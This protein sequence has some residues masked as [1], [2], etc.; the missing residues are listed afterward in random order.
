MVNGATNS[1]FL[2]LG[3]LDVWSFVGTVGDSNV[4]RVTASTFNPWIRLYDP[5]GDL[6]GEAVSPRFDTRSL[7]LIYEITKEPGIYTVV[8][9]STTGGYSSAYTFKQSRWA[10]DLL[11]P[12][13]QSIDEGGTLNVSISAQDP[14]EPSKPLQFKLLSAPP[15][16]NFQMAG[17]TNA[18]LS[19][20]TSEADGPSTNVVVA[21]VTDVVNGR[22]FTRTNEFTVIVREINVAPQL[23]V[24]A[25]Q[26]IDELTPLNVSAS[27]TDVDLP[28]NPLSFSLVDQPAGMTIGA[29]SGAISWTPSEAQGPSVN[30]I[31]VVVTDDSPFAV[32]A[33]HLSTTNQFTVTVHEVNL[34]PKLTVSAA[35]AVDELK[36]LNVSA[37]ATD[38]DLPLNTLTFSLITPPE[39]MKINPATGAIT[40][41]PTEAQGAGSYTVTVEVRDNGLPPLSATA[42][43]P[44]VV[45]EVNLA[46]TLPTQIGHTIDELTP[47]TVVNTGADADMPANTLAYALVSPPTGATI[48]AT[49]VITWTPT[50]AQGATTNIFTTVVTDNGL[51]SLSATNAFT[52]VVREINSAPVLT[53]PG[54]QTIDELTPLKVSASAA[55]SDVP[56]NALTY[57]LVSPP[58]GMKIDAATGAITWIP[59]EAQGPS[60][61]VIQ[62]TL[63]DN[64]PAASVSPQLSVAASFTVIV[65]EVNVAPKIEAIA[66]QSLHFGTLLSIKSVASDAD[67]P[68]NTLLFSLEESL[69]GLTIDSS[70]GAVSWTPTQAQVGTPT[71]TV[72]VSDNGSTALSAT[73]SFKVNVAGEGSQ[74]SVELLPGGLAQISASGD[75]G[76]DYELQRSLDLVKWDKL[77]EFRLTGATYP[78]IDPESRT[79]LLGFYRIKLVR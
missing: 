23:T 38:P 15:G 1:A 76:H 61:N 22:T 45:N 64:N 54:T 14:D 68:A 78:Y 4:L 41:T 18:T 65:N 25:N 31:T 30:T 8:I 34:P 11:V 35:Q 20:A 13:T 24:P 36:L 21:S 46:P 32:N 33:Q 75:A 40:W 67:L 17:A 49:G 55:D 50:E 7:N 27:A 9:S 63:T 74:L 12:E 19:W 42:S 52:V 16:V 56:P 71:L 2:N 59:T 51:P 39:G 73:A 62:V 5:T 43:F 26:V 60:T 6:V 77:I 47:L 57:A 66:D 29:S 3:D 53:V 58:E 79:G 37:S 70:T 72:R 28:P 69:P 44:V 48:S 10:P